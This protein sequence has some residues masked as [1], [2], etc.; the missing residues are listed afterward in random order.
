MKM[1][2]LLS[3][4]LEQDARSPFCI[5]TC[6]LAFYILTFALHLETLRCAQGDSD[7]GQVWGPDTHG[8]GL[9]AFGQV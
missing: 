4:S 5:L 2:I 1:Q 8:E 6:S 3:C 9:S 7:A